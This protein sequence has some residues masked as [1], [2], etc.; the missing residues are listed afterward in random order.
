MRWLKVED[1]INPAVCSDIN[2]ILT[3]A[4]QNVPFL[5][6]VKK[7]KEGNGAVYS[8]RRTDHSERNSL[9]CCFRTC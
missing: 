4:L 8:Q 9:H 3:F 5:Q 6:E 7:C 2:L 1:G